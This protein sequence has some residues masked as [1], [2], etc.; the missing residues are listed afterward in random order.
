MTPRRPSSIPDHPHI[1][2]SCSAGNSS[3][4]RGG[5]LPLLAIVLFTIFCLPS[6]ADEVTDCSEDGFL[7]ALSFDNQALFTED[8]SITLTAP[9]PITADTL[10][11][12]QGHNV[13]ISGDNQLLIFEV[14]EPA[15]LTILGVTITGGQNTNGGAIFVNGGSILVLSNCTLSANQA[16]G[17]NG[18]DG[19]NGS[20]VQLGN[21]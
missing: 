19:A 20:S 1:K 14:E 18:V 9:V 21:G 5:C 10:I 7:A 6:F 12:A 17:T 4:Q 13:S 8:C 15:T 3:G 2:I 16:I 11:D